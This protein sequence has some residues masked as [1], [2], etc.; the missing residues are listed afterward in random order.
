MPTN[1]FGFFLLH[2]RLYLRL[3]EKWGSRHSST[4]S[5][6]G[7]TNT[8]W[9]AH[10]GLSTPMLVVALLWGKFAEKV[11]PVAAAPIISLV[12]WSFTQGKGL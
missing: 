3:D 8:R 1:V 2:V 4:L 12:L 11:A 9:A 10:L 6:D 7:R 5:L